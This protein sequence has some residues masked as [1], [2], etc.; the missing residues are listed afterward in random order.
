[1]L[2]ELSD[3]KTR[4][5]LDRQS[6]FGEADG[7]RLPQHVDEARILAIA[8]TKGDGVSQDDACF[9]VHYLSRSLTLRLHAISAKLGQMVFLAVFD[10]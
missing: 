1:M 3:G 10:H 2:F 5:G 4:G 8:L 6:V 9:L 7:A